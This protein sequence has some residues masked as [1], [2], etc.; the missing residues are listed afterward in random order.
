[1]R[2][3]VREGRKND[4]IFIIKNWIQ[5]GDDAQKFLLYTAV[6][7]SCDAATILLKRYG[8]KCL[9]KAAECTDSKRK[10]ELESM[11]DNLIWISGNPG[12]SFREA[13]QAAITYQYLVD[14]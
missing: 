10:A 12:C 2:Q 4:I 7:I 3:R 13:C 1:M 11:A 5:A 9:E 6:V 8:A 14:P